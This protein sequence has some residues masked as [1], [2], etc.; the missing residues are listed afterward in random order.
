M[1]NQQEPNASVIA[2]SK[3]NIIAIGTESTIIE[4]KGAS[5][6]L[7]DMAGAFITPGSICSHV[8]LMMCSK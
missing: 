4:F 7:L 6:E 3:D 2:F 8:H 1:A 5:T